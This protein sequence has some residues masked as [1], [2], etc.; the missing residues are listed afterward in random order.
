LYL[1]F[2][3]LVLTAMTALVSRH[4]FVKLCLICIDAFLTKNRQAHQ[5]PDVHVINALGRWVT[6]VGGLSAWHEHSRLRFA[7]PV[8]S[9]TKQR[10][11]ILKTYNCKLVPV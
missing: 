6:R 10:T 7:L 11:L 3:V 4:T 9:V 8:W 1:F 2:T 5:V